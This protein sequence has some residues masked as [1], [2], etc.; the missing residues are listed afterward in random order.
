MQMRQVKSSNVSAVGYDDVTR[1]M[2]VTFKSGGTYLYDGVPPELHDRMREIE[3][4]GG[5]VGQFIVR[6]IRDC[7][8]CY[9]APSPDLAA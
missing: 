8:P 3:D 5:S 7:F 2:M 9:R 1:A 4:T 6:N